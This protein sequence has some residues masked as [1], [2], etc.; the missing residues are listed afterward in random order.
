[1]RCQKSTRPVQSGSPSRSDNCRKNLQNTSAIGAKDSFAWGWP[2]DALAAIGTSTNDTDTTVHRNNLRF[3]LPG[4]HRR[5]A[6]GWVEPS[7]S[8]SGETL[9]IEESMTLRA[10]TEPVGDVG[11]EHEWGWPRS[12]G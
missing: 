4:A 6:L 1:M 9:S 11:D 10:R 8:T 5:R 12:S 7:L 2:D 3:N